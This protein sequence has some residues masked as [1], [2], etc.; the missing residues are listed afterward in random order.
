MRTV[1]ICTVGTNPKKLASEKDRKFVDFVEE[2][3]MKQKQ[4]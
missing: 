3:W 2:I 4:P 1:M